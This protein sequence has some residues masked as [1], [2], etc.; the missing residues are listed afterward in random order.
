MKSNEARSSLPA[1]GTLQIH[2]LEMDKKGMD[3]ILV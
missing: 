1:N 3:K 2:A